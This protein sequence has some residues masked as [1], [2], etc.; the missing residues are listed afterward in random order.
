MQAGLTSPEDQEA[1]MAEAL[2]ADRD[3]AAGIFD[4]D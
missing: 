2:I 1:Y 4:E 3:V